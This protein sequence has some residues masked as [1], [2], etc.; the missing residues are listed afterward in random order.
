MAITEKEEVKEKIEAKEEKKEKSW[1]KQIPTGIL[2]GGGFL[3]FLALRSIMM[4]KGGT[5]PILII[6]GIIILLLLMSKKYEG[7][8][9]VLS[10]K[11]AEFYAERE[12][13]RKQAWGQF[14]TMDKFY[15]GPVN[16]AKKSDGAGQYYSVAMM[17]KTP[18]KGRKYYEVTVPMTGLEK[19]FPSF[20]E[21]IIPVSGRE[22][23]NERTLFGMSRKLR[24]DPLFQ[25]LFK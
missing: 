7:V 3:I 8:G 21:A 19:G 15:P 14:S 6:G 1:W 18:F 13:Y 5:N 23:I 16:K 22:V 2:V 20:G 12:C 4:E 11:E 10:P 9:E 25:K 24:G 17:V